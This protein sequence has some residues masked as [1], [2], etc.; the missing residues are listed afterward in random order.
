MNIC[1]IL[2]I[3]CG[4]EELHIC[5]IKCKKDERKMEEELRGLVTARPRSLHFRI[6]SGSN[7]RIA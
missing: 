5:Q 3:V 1:K 2:R 7:G 4:T 6:N